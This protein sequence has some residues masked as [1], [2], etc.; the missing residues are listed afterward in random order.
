MTVD[1]GKNFEGQ[2]GYPTPNETPGTTVCR[3]FRVPASDDWLGVLMAAA[4]TL[5]KD[6][7]WYN[8]GSMTI[9][10]VTQAWNDIIIASY[11]ESLEGTCPSNTVDTPYWDEDTEVDDEMSIDTQ[12]W[13]GEVADPM[14]APTSLTFIENAAVWAFTGLLAVG[15]DVNLAI[16]FHTIAPKFI[17][18]VKQAN[19]GN[20]IRI[21]VDGEK[22]AEITDAGD[23]SVM[24]IPIVADPSLSAHDIYWTV[25]AA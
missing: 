12:T 1:P 9:D 11:E 16:A 4:E 23:N 2:T 10:E 17:L 20:I 18:S 14:V 22:A 8:W 3:V 21:F 15:V 24:D 25:G 13:Y 6:Y 7:N 19:F 5:T